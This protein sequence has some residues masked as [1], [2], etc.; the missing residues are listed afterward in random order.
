[1]KEDLMNTAGKIRALLAA[2][3]QVSAVVTFGASV[4]HTRLENIFLEIR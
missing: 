1:V 4:P 3:S 2:F